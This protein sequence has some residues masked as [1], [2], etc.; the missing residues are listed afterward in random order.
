[1][2]LCIGEKKFIYEYGIIRVMIA[3]DPNGTLFFLKE[4][5][6]AMRKRRDPPSQSVEIINDSTVLLLTKAYFSLPFIF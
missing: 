1:M 6:Q 4:C 5:F 2:F 3:S